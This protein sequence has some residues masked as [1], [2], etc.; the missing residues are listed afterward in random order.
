[1]LANRE[2]GVVVTRGGGFHPLV[3]GAT[4]DRVARTLSRC[5]LQHECRRMRRITSC[6]GDGQEQPQSWR[7]RWCEAHAT[8]GLPTGLLTILPILHSLDIPAP[9]RQE[10]WRTA[11][12]GFA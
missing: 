10:P 12:Q 2:I 9:L 4:R 11:P 8:P 3:P 7:P 1:M 5:H 6:G